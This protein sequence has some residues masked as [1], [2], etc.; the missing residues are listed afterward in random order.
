MSAIRST[1]ER[2]I[3]AL[4]GL[5]LAQVQADLAAQLQVG[6]VAPPW[7]VAGSTGLGPAGAAVPV[8]LDRE[9]ALRREQVPAVVLEPA[10]TAGIRREDGEVGTTGTYQVVLRLALGV[11]TRGDPQAIRADAVFAP[12]HARLMIDPTLGGTATWLRLTE[13]T[14][15][16]DDADGTSGWLVA[17][18]DVSLALDEVALTSVLI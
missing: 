5:T 3:A 2:A 8:Y 9:P 16:R 18:Y 10:G 15:Q 13:I 7:S 17:M 12:A 4:T 1:L 14:F 11:M 6:G